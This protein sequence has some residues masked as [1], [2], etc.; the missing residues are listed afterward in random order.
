MNLN[1][2]AAQ[3]IV[4]T[5]L[6]KTASVT[7]RL[8]AVQM[9]IM[10][11]TQ[12]TVL[13]IL[14]FIAASLIIGK[15]T[16]TV[17]V[18]QASFVVQINIILTIQNIVYVMILLY[19]VN[20]QIHGEITFYVLA[21]V[22]KIAA[23]AMVTILIPTHKIA[24]ATPNFSAV[25]QMI[26]QPII[27]VTVTQK[28]AAAVVILSSPTPKIAIVNLKTDVAREI[29]SQK[30]NNALATHHKNVALTIS[31]PV[32]QAKIMPFAVI[33]RPNAVLMILI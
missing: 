33:K 8:N 19:A 1:T 32:A 11:A 27:F 26:A 31:T 20:R 22:Q 28:F 29:L 14:K 15:Q 21:T 4:G 7:Q 25:H 3:K 16:K 9:I 2:I 10:K 17:I 18:I 6:T 12:I 5:H 13:V 24:F 23:L 30:T